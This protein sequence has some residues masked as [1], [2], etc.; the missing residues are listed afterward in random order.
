MIGLLTL[1]YFIP[2]KDF[3]TTFF[4][5]GSKP[6]AYPQMTTLYQRIFLHCNE[7]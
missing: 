4:K 2:L 1:S 7:H 5:R 6:I 3:Y